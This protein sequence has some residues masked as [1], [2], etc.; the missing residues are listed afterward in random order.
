MRKRLIQAG[1]VLFAA[2]ILALE[3]YAISTD[4]RG[5]TISEGVW[6]IIFAHPLIWL[7]T[8][9]ATL[10]LLYWSVKHFWWRQR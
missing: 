7:T 2:G 5:D 1:Y 4:E 8:L 10:G 3:A 9:G 6:T